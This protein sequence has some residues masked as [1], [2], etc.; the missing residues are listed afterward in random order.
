VK[1][2][3]A[4]TEANKGGKII[5]TGIVI[6]AAMLDAKGIGLALQRTGGANYTINIDRYHYSA[7]GRGSKRLYDIN[8]VAGSFSTTTTQIFYA[9]QELI[10]LPN[11]PDLTVGSLYI[12]HFRTSTWINDITAQTNNAGTQY[13]EGT[14]SSG[15]SLQT[16]SQIPKPLPVTFLD[17]LG[18]RKDDKTILLKWATVA[19]ID[20][21][22][23]D[24]EM[25]HDGFNFV[26][27]GF[28]NGNNN[29]TGST[30]YTFNYNCPKNAY[31]R[32]KQVDFSGNFSHS[33]VIFIRGHDADLLVYPNP[34]TNDEQIN[35]SILGINIATEK[36]KFVVTD[37][38]GKIIFETSNM[39]DK[40]EKELQILFANQISSGT[41]LLSVH[42]HEK[43]HYVKIVKN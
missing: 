25:S 4:T 12:N 34:I 22:G 6:T 10:N 13:V 42:T 33:K 31:F 17:F 29:K 32:L 16:L 41:Y 9:S 37:T 28:Q 5:C 30:E 24:I 27:V 11:E 14:N 39:F 1:D 26:K 18:M 23:F 40:A 7:L 38:S 2:A 36:V 43:S 3:T 8:L 21:K 20:N 19:E 15:Y 35:L